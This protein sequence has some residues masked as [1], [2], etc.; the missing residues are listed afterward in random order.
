MTLHVGHFKFYSI[1][2]LKQAK[3]K[4]CPH[5][6]FL[7]NVISSKQIIQVVSKISEFGI[8]TSGSA[9]KEFTIFR[10]F[11]SMDPDL[12]NFIKVSNISPS[13]YRGNWPAEKTHQKSL[14][15]IIKIKESKQNLEIFKMNPLSTNWVHKYISKQPREYLKLC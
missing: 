6:S 5:D 13:K 12:Y 7:A 8:F 15:F 14:K 9:F 4:T 3:W 2:L 1:H 10:D 11:I